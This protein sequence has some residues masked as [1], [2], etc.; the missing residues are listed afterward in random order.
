MKISII[1][2]TLF[3]SISKANADWI[4]VQSSDNKSTDLYIDGESI[5]II[6][7]DIRRYWSK[8]NLQESEVTKYGNYQSM[9][10]FNEIDCK[11]KK[12]RALSISFY[13][14]NDLLGKVIHSQEDENSK[15][16]FIPPNSL[17]SIA[18]DIVCSIK[19]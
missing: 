14:K 3:I 4:F 17:G 6:N 16:S 8:N 11:N 7:K 1:F 12:F 10:A 9:R 19:K 2:L 5:Q 15:W 13:E 18:S